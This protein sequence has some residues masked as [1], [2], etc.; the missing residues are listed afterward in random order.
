MSEKKRTKGKKKKIQ[1]LEERKPQIKIGYGNP[2]E[3]IAHQLIDKL[4]SLTISQSFKNRVYSNEVFGTYCT[5]YC[6]EMVVPLVEVFA[7]RHDRDDL[8]DNEE[9]WRTVPEVERVTFDRDTHTFVHVES[10]HNKSNAFNEI[11]EKEVSKIQKLISNKRNSLKLLKKKKEY[12]S[13]RNVAELP[14]KES[15]HS[16]ASKDSITHNQSSNGKGSNSEKEIG[17]KVNND[18]IK[19]QRIIELPSYDIKGISIQEENEEV[20]KLREEREQFIIQKREKELKEQKKKEE[21]KQKQNPSMFLN[22][23]NKQT[24]FIPVKLDLN[25]YTFDPD[26]KIVPYRIIPQ[27]NFINEFSEIV[28]EDKFVKEVSPITEEHHD[29]L[30]STRRMKDNEIVTYNN[31]LDKTTTTKKRT[32][33]K[34]SKVPIFNRIEKNAYCQPAGDNFSIITPETGVIVKYDKEKTKIGNMSFLKKYNK[35]SSLDFTNVLNETMSKNKQSANNSM[36]DINDISKNIND[37]SLNMSNASIS[38][39]FAVSQKLRDIK[40]NSLNTGSHKYNSLNNSMSIG[41][42]ILSKNKSSVDLLETF[43]S[44]EQLPEIGSKSNTNKTIKNIFKDFFTRKYYQRKIKEEKANT[45]RQ[46]KL[47]RN[48]SLESINK[49]TV[50]IAQNLNFGITTKNEIKEEKEPYIKLP[51]KPNPFHMIRQNGILVKPLRSFR[52]NYQMK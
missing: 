39:L 2:S 42:I 9:N 1:Q 10:T 7:V 21:L 48:K 37:S 14:D 20:L 12:I 44:N 3:L 34:F 32:L 36:M 15:T 43:D 35:F 45:E 31:D 52:V 28:S 40:M 47:K 50:K 22:P 17:S 24:N 5:R 25:R 29:S 26:G 46:K 30:L 16:H 19:K 51:F 18:K 33:Q 23:M 49:F 6:Y 13:T 27:S 4:I 41:K 8:Y 11:K 38:K